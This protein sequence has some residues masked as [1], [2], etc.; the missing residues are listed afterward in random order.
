[1]MHAIKAMC[2]SRITY[3]APTSARLCTIATHHGYAE[4]VLISVNLL[5][6]SSPLTPC[7]LFCVEFAI[8]DRRGLVKI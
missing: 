5:G 3:C 2:S 1:M 8:Y 6:A 7:I 4:K